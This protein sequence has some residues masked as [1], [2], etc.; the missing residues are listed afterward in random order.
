[1]DLSKVMAISGKSGLFK[2][3]SQSRGSIIVE[4]LVDGKKIPVF[5]THRSS[6]LE[7]ISMFTYSEDV[8]LKKVLWAIY[9]K[10]EGKSISIDLKNEGSPLKEYFESVLPDY[11]KER[12]Y[13]SDI[14]KVFVWYNQLLEHN[15]IS[16]PIEEEKTEASEEVNDEPAKTEEVKKTA[17]KAPKKD[18]KDSKK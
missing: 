4:S 11:D 17:K 10:E 18:Q 15:L 9:Q 12:V 14:K 3:V 1:M 16:E 6:I 13:A 8:P 2:I 5:A 7:D